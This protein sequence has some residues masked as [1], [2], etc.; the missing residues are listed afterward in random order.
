MLHLLRVLPYPRAPGGKPLG[1]HAG[2]MSSKPAAAGSARMRST[3]TGGEAWPSPVSGAVL[4]TAGP[5]GPGVR[6]AVL[7]RVGLS[8]GCWAV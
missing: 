7:C 4:R 8:G 1:S 3:S 6:G 2:R 5:L